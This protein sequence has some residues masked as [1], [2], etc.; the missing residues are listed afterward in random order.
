MNNTGQVAS[1]TRLR[2][3]QLI[4]DLHYQPSPFARGLAS[5]T[6]RIMGVMIFDKLD[7]G[8]FQ[9]MFQGVE[10]EVRVRGYDLLIFSHP[11]VR[12]GYANS[13]LRMVDGVLCFGYDFDDET[14][15]NLESME[16]PHVVIG[17]RE[18]RNTAPWFCTADYFNGFRR[19]THYLMDMG[20]QRIALMG[21]SSDFAPDKEKYSGF[22]TALDEGGIKNGFVLLNNNIEHIREVLENFRPTAVIMDGTVI[23]LPLLLCIKQMGL[24]VPRDI[25]LV[26]TRRDFIDIHT[27]Y[28]FTGIHELTLM[29]IPRRE[30]GVAGVT[31][32][33]R[34]IDGEK[35][36]PREQNI[37]MEFVAG[38]SCAPP[39]RTGTKVP[40]REKQ[41]KEEAWV[42]R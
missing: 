41:M 26:Y 10:H 1:G 42:K 18:W 16:I 19:A 6:S 28:D 39:R 13:C 3:Q 38:E 29:K 4:D 22:K 15:E 21:I 20:H 7:F 36:I 24:R 8:F 40:L 33:R 23:P 14:I 11:E 35:D 25:S 12:E 32:L 30:L 5:H 2:I 31:L 17:K 34:L 9:P 27:L 37:D